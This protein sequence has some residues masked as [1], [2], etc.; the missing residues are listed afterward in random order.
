MKHFRFLLLL[1]FALFAKSVFAQTDTKFWFAAPEITSGHGDSPI[2][3][4]IATFSDPAIVTISIPANPGFTPIVLAVP[5]NTA[6]SQ[7]LTASK[8]LLE[9]DHNAIS[10]KG[11]LIESTKTITAYYE[12]ARSNNTD[13]FALKGRNA[14]GSKFYMPYEHHWNHKTALTPKG[15]T[16]A[17]VVATEDGT[18]VTFT[19]TKNIVYG[20][21]TVRP[22]GIPYTVYLDRGEVYSLSHEEPSGANTPVGTLIESTQPIAVTLSQDS[23]H[24]GT[25]GCYDILG[26]QIVPVDLLGTSHIIMRGFLGVGGTAQN[27]KIVITATQNG[28]TADFNGIA[29]PGGPFNAGESRVVSISTA[30]PRNSLIANKPVYVMHYS[31]Y[32]CEGGGALIPPMVCTG[33]RKVYFTRSTSEHFGVNLLVGAGHQG[34]FTLNGVPIP[35]GS[36]AAVPGTGGAYYSAQITYLVADVPVGTASVIENS[37]SLFHLGVINGGASSGCRYG[38]FSSF[39]AVSLGPDI[40]VSYGSTITLDAGTPFGVSYLWSNGATTQTISVGIWELGSYWVEV[41][42]GICKLTDAVCIGTYEYVWMGYQDRNWNNPNNWSKPCGVVTPPTCNDDVIIIKDAY[43]FPLI[44]AADGDA[45]CRKLDMRLDSEIEFSATGTLNICGDFIHAGDLLTVPGSTIRFIGNAQG[46]KYSFDNATA[47]GLLE[48]VVINNTTPSTSTLAWD[49]VVV[50]ST[51]GYGNMVISPTGSLTMLNGILQ[52]SS[53]REVIVQ[54]RTTSSVSMHNVN[55]YVAGRLRRYVN[56]VGSYDLPVGLALPVPPV[57]ANTKTA[58]LSGG[59]TWVT[60]TVCGSSTTVVNLNG[61]GQRIALPSAAVIIGNTP[62]TL[63]IWAKTNAFNGGALIAYGNLSGN[64]G[65][66]LRTRNGVANGWRIETGG[67]G[68]DFTLA[69]SNTGWHHYALTYDGGTLNLYYDGVLAQTINIGLNTV[70]ANRFIGRY[71]A[72]TP[73]DFNGRVEN[74]KVFNINLT[75]TEINSRKCEVYGCSLAPPAN[76]IC[77]YDFQEGA[78]ASAYYKTYTCFPPNKTYQNANIDF[79]EPNTPDYLLAFFNKYSSVPGPTGQLSICGANWDVC[80]ALNNGFWTINAFLPGDIATSGSPVSRYTA[81]LYNR[82]YSNAC[83]GGTVMK[84]ANSGDPWSIPTGG[85]VDDN[86]ASVARGWLRGFSDF[87]TAQSTDPIIL[88]VDLVSLE[89]KPGTS[90]IFVHWKTAS[91]KGNMGFDVMRSDD[92]IHFEKIGYVKGNGSTAQS[93]NYVLEDKNVRTGKLY[94]YR[95]KQYDEDG[96]SSLT[97]IVS[98]IIKANE[99]SASIVGVFPNPTDGILNIDFSGLDAAAFKEANVQV[100]TTLGVQLENFELNLEEKSVYEINLQKYAAGMYLL[101]VQSGE[102]R[103]RKSVV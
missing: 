39:N 83:G 29:V 88:P 102:F 73:I 79:V 26:D 13:I 55:S 66:V 28:T 81:T 75:D 58:T 30:D 87:A 78:G 48:N 91:E 21:V 77:L 72:G 34:N 92:G 33:S 99:N 59:P 65:L 101:V 18:E 89:A 50:D 41:N 96:N 98:A 47:T 23:K 76:L 10:Q 68:F 8:G 84:R 80:N 15:H 6:V 62:R 22:A 82:D 94:Y 31:G 19:P 63:M 52:T 74:F 51:A 1:T 45:Y 20:G 38:Y 61:S 9:A 103:D 25:G 56:A 70:D 97:K 40:T 4:R 14:L 17:V 27:E 3:V 43:R 53:T 85:C 7:D 2:Y 64:Q 5:A 67:S 100:F 95:L 69:G 90:S 86:L 60:E 71:P 57:V 36:F 42:L 46:Q 35:A 32:G 11:L 16:A 24:S 44:T 12:V 37:T 93:N 49:Y 54:N